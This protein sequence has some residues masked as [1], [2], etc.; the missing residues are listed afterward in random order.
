VAI[1]WESLV[2]S[3]AVATGVTLFI[4]VTAKPW[5]ELR[6]DRILRR[7]RDVE[8]LVAQLLAIEGAVITAKSKLTSIWEPG[9]FLRDLD[10]KVAA[11]RSQKSLGGSMPRPLRLLLVRGLGLIA[12]FVAV[13][14]I[15]YVSFEE[16]FGASPLTDTHARRATGDTLALVDEVIRLPLQYLMTPKYRILKRRELIKR[17]RRLIDEDPGFLSLVN[18]NRD[19]VLASKPDKRSKDA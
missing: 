3:A 5:L 6:K 8:S 10:G 16:E 13:A 17:A 15:V 11:L 18:R 4:E 12:G 7:S 2:A 19:R 9:E 14:A 1:Q